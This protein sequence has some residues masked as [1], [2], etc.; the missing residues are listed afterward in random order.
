MVC[1]QTSDASYSCSISGSTVKVVK[2]C[3][4]SEEK[5]IEASARKNCLAYA[6]QCDEPVK[7]V[8]HCVINTYVNQTVEVCAYAQ[9]IALGRIVKCV[10]SPE[11][12]NMFTVYTIFFFNLY[13][14][15]NF[16]NLHKFSCLNKNA[17]MFITSPTLVFTSTRCF[18]PYIDKKKMKTVC[19]LPW[20]YVI[21]M[22]FLN[23]VLKTGY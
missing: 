13:I 2:N 3:P 20:A 17:K 10:R 9:N 4:D 14:Y 21:L 22:N 1:L 5:W 18:N 7:L 8:Y 16:E 11:L 6:S 19:F 23:Y 12:Q 15:K